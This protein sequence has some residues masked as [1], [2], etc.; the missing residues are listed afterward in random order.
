MDEPVNKVVRINGLFRNILVTGVLTLLVCSNLSAYAQQVPPAQAGTASSN[1][2]APSAAI[3]TNNNLQ[4]IPPPNQSAPLPPSPPVV[5][6]NNNQNNALSSGNALQ[7][8]TSDA[9]QSAPADAGL[10]SPAV[11]EAA[12]DLAFN[13]MTSNALPMSNREIVK[14]K[15]LFA[16][17]NQAAATAISGAPPKAVVTTQLVSL[18]P[19]A[20]LPIIRPSQGYVT[21][22][23]FLDQTGAPWAIHSYD[24]G[25]PGA[26]D[27][28]WDQTGNKNILLLQP[29]ALY[30]NA[31]L[32]V[33]LEGCST[34]INVSLI[35]GQPSVD[36][37][38]DMRVPGLSPNNKSSNIIPTLPAAASN[39]LLN[40]LD[41]VPPAKSKALAIPGSNS[42]VWLHS[43]AKTM[44][45]RTHD[46]L[47]SPAF[48]ARMSSPDGMNA[49]Q[50]P[51][52]TSLLV[53]GKDGQIHSES[54][55][56]Y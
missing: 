54:V 7:D 11:D 10:P 14:L 2:L 12:H 3:P 38:V 47:L 52:V 49:Y 6:M 53:S 24:I 23:V 15:N 26:F 13:A 48:I 29:K 33:Q 44:Y 50:I 17:A 20:E 32:V 39:E 36:A 27:V 34:P 22:I 55:E 18:E 37:R 45:L 25:N 4:K 5:V 42:Q 8:Q 46:T 41:G 35:P 31:S 56:G 40:V 51:K 19:G 43:D 28:Q 1:A 16:G 9:T 30:T 21:A